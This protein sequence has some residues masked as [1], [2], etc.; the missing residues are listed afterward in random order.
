MHRTSGVSRKCR[1]PMRFRVYR[2]TRWKCKHFCVLLENHA[3]ARHGTERNGAP[4]HAS[5]SRDDLDSS[6]A[7]TE[8]YVRSKHQASFCTAAQLV[9][10]VRRS[11]RAF[12][13]SP[14]CTEQ[15][16][17]T[18]APV[19]LLIDT[20]SVDRSSR[21]TFHECRS[22]RLSACKHRSVKRSS[23]EFIAPREYRENINFMAMLTTGRLVFAPLLFPFL[24]SL[25]KTEK[26]KK[27]QEQKI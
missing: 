11:A 2:V 12:S 13:R 22:P 5:S 24:G 27:T 23:G 3:A 25:L 26:K 6:K 10:P 8:R 16:P 15:G 20:N 7:L 21:T 4:R 19:R 18:R 17:G 14:W 9:R 1:K